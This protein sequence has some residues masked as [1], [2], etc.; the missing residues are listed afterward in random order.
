MTFFT[1][2]YLFYQTKLKRTDL[3]NADL[4]ADLSAEKIGGNPLLG[5]KE[6]FTNP[7]L[8]GIGVFIILYTGIGSFIYLE[9]KNLLADYS[10][11]DR[12]SIYGL[13]DA[14]SNTITFVLAF[15]PAIF[16]FERRPEILK[17]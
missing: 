10:R 9:Q 4:H 12:T 5:F 14:I 3:N 13:R 17:T 8:L 11:A 15:F 2:Y 16:T 7:Y 6:F 1:K